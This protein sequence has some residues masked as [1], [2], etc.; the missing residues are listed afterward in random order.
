M[1]THHKPLDDGNW[2]RR[3]ADAH[4]WLPDEEQIRAIYRFIYRHVGNREDAESL[5]ERACS[6]AVWAARS[7]PDGQ[8]LD[9]SLWQVA[10]AVV[11]EHRRW[12]YG[13]LAVDSPAFEQAG[14][15]IGEGEAPPDAQSDPPAQVA[16]I[17]AQLPP[18]ERDVLTH[19][20]LDNLSL[21]D[22][23]TALR[24]TPSEAQSL[25]WYA[26]VRAARVA[27]QLRGASRQRKEIQD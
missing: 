4:G 1:P 8:P 23:A 5:T 10:H 27:T 12:F 18:H 22:A 3:S 7:L 16:R 14:G 25:Q 11:G 21:A 20:F 13:A 6:E 15:L 9:E 24:I 19:R 26:L 2:R 17:L